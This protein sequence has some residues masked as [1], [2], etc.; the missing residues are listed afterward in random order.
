M[1]NVLILLG[2]FSLSA[3][4][5]L[6]WVDPLTKLEWAFLSHGL[7]WNDAVEGCKN[8]GYFL[9]T[10][11]EVMVA[12]KRLNKS[13]VGQEVRKGSCKVFHLLTGAPS[14]NFD[15]KAH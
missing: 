10:R 4:A 15:K 3:N 9:P 2:L 14:C 5:Q 11:T 7:E 13:I 6:T 12:H 8:I 1:K